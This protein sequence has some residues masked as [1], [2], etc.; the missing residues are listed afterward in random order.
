MKQTLKEN[1][2]M[3][4][5]T[6]GSVL[7]DCLEFL[8]HET[9]PGVSTKSIELKADEFIAS[10]NAKPAF[11]GYKGFPSSICASK[12]NVVV[13]GIPSEKEV[14]ESGDILSVDVGVKYKGY[15][16]DAARTFPVGKISEDAEKLIAVTKEALKR[17]IRMAKRGNRI[18]DISWAIQSYVESNGFSVVRAFVGHGIGKN[19]HEEPEVPNFGEPNKGKMLEDGMALAIEPMVNAGTDDVKILDDGW[20]AVT[21][22]S[23]LSAH[24]ENTVIINGKSPEIVT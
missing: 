12:N 19:L 20:T 3:F 21:K 17:G 18:G 6:A 7:K 8:S 5:R 10:R 9:R 24:F 4:L 2:L 1:Q 16:A 22:D 23:A 13:H 14:L 11:R 15:F